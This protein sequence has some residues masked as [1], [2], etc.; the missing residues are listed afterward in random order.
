MSYL[1]W[2][3]QSIDPFLIAPYRWLSN[4]LLGWLWGT[5]V[6][7]M[8][9]TILG[10]L[11]LALAYRVNRSKVKEVAE[12]T[13][14]LL[15]KSLAAHRAG[16]KRSYKAINR[17]ANEAYGK[18]FFLQMAMGM[19]A[20]WPA[21]LGAAWLQERFG[22]ITWPLPWVGYELNFVGPYLVLYILARVIF[23]RTRRRLPYFR[24]LMTG[25]G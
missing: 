15:E 25:G 14:D 11:T 22:K 20:L 9:A 16:D 24:R 17:L 3:V 19:S 7:S 21:F 8:W 1:D 2:F 6:L 18:T 13:E 4:P 12:E 10:E 23:A 5:F